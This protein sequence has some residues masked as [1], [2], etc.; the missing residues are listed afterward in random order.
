MIKNVFFFN[1]FCGIL[2]FTDK[3]EQ[4]WSYCKKAASTI[5]GTLMEKAAIIPL[6]GCNKVRNIKKMS[7]TFIH[8]CRTSINEGTG[9]DKT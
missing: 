7:T 8:L 2:T 5:G 4:A 6:H 9:Y 1:I 3:P